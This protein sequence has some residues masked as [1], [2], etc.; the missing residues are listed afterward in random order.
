MSRTCIHGGVKDQLDHY[1]RYD[2]ATGC[3]VWTG[4]TD[5]NGY[6]K[7][8]VKY[9]VLRAHRVAY[10]E[11]IGAIPDGLVVCHRCDNPACINPRHLILGTHAD[12]I[13]D[14]DAK[15]RHVPAPGESNGMAKLTDDD[16][17]A[18]KTATGSQREIAA[19]FGICQQNVSQIKR[20]IR[21]K[22]IR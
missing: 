11:H 12:N 8:T 3:I 18:I 4:A 16:I 2:N 10:E 14:R 1:G 21:W 7:I 13:A 15:L 9:K 17:R 6:G 19:A 22:H 5:K 20:G